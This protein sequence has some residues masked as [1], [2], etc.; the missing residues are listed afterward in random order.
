MS[1]SQSH[2]IKL[3]FPYTFESSAPAQAY[4]AFLQRFTA[5]RVKD[6]IDTSEFITTAPHQQLATSSLW[7]I[8]PN[9][10]DKRFHHFATGLLDGCQKDEYQNGFFGLP[11]LSL[12]K[13]ALRVLNNGTPN[14]LGQGVNV[15]L[16]KAAIARLK[17]LDIASPSAGSQ[18]PMMFNEIQFFALSIGVGM[19]VI[20]VSFKQPLKNGLAIEH[21]EE[22]LEINY[23]IARNSNDHQS[24]A[25]HWQ[26]ENTQEI[27]SQSIT[28]GLSPLV[29]S[30]IPTA[31]Q[32]LKLT[33]CKDRNNTYS[34]VFL[35]SDK[36]LKIQQKENFIF[37]MARKYNDRYLPKNPQQQLSYFEPFETITHAFSLEGCCTFVDCAPYQGDIPESIKNFR[38]T[39]V[40]QAYAP[41]ILLT[42]AEYIF[43]REMAAHSQIETKV[44]MSNPSENNLNKLREFRS[45]LYDFRLNY[46]FTQ[47]SSNTNHNLF[48]SANK[49]ALQIEKLLSDTSNDVDEV[50]QYIA[51]QVS[52]QQQ[53]RLKKFG[54]MGSLFA[55]II[56]WVDLWGLN[57]NEIIYGSKNVEPASIVVFILVLVALT[58]TVL[59]TSRAP[60]SKPTRTK[61]AATAMNRPN[62]ENSSKN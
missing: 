4:V 51:D 52:Q 32:N 48:C 20:D 50:E 12:S 58:T 8:T 25:I 3:Y 1:I 23:A 17:E 44:D 61:L 36:S 62:K 6:F 24:P 19:L 47:I 18:W 15:S 57:F 33:P 40:Q 41:L 22:L 53:A 43:L 13:D 31:E 30:L 49:Q 37:R 34:Y 7:Q 29:D 56:G 27:S 28:K 54:V 55:A 5:L 60:S 42:Y 2:S 38:K 16:K 26:N 45:K 21:L 35:A 59:I 14:Q 9:K 39:A 11:T 10:L 46:R